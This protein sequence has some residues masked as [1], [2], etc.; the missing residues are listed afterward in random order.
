[1]T[2]R[3]F[4]DLR[5]VTRILM[6]S[7]AYLHFVVPRLTIKNEKWTRPVRSSHLRNHHFPRSFFTLD[8]GHVMVALA[9]FERGN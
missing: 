6:C 1:M 4:V 3:R 9:K 5:L 2:K 7:R 8:P